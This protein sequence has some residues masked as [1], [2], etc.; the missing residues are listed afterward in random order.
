M[1]VLI[2]CEFSGTVRD[3]FSEKGH[4]AWSCDLLPTEKKGN[5]IQGDVLKILGEDWD[6]MI[7]HPP[8]TYLS[9]V[10][11]KWLKTDPTRKGKRED[12]LRFFLS[13]Y[14]SKIPKICCENPLGYVNSA[15]RKP[16]QII[17]PF[18]FGDSF[19]KRT[20]LWLKG[21]PRLHYVLEDDLFLKK[22]A[23]TKPKPIHFDKNGVAKHW[24]EMLVRMP[25]KDRWKERS[26]TFPGIAK[27]M[28]EQW[29]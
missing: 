12:A 16:D 20:C 21:L 6:L 28:A 5:H 22:T 3:A 8:C 24:C 26:K 14:N 29:G 23:C 15:F 9:V 25:L 18:F 1:K 13:L 10:G 27:A 4:D 17:H 19:L 7:A 11:N 2:A